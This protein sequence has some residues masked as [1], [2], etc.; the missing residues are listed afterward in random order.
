MRKIIATRGRF[1]VRHFLGALII[2][3]IHCVC[4][5]VCVRACVRACVRV[6]V[7]VCQGID[8]SGVEDMEWTHPQAHIIHQWEPN[9]PVGD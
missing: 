5:C 9:L 1:S 8:T 7:C 2:K 3:C 6:C 4:V